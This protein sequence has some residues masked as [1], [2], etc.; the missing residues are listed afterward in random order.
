VLTT[1]E[2]LDEADATFDVVL[3]DLVRLLLAV[4]DS[5]AGGLRLHALLGER[6][7]QVLSAR[8]EYGGDKSIVPRLRWPAST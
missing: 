8:G 7:R 4:G 2:I 6:D 1:G 3:S 5:P